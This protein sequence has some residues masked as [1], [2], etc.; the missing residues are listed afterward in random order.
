M[1]TTRLLAGSLIALSIAVQSR[2]AAAPIWKEYANPRFAFRVCYPSWL[3][4]GREPD[5][6][7]GRIFTD[8]SNGEMR[9]WGS[10][11]TLVLINGQEQESDEAPAA[12][13]VRQAADFD[14][15]SFSRVTYRAVHRNWF[16][17]SG[18]KKR[19]IVYVKTIKSDDRWITLQVS[20]PI[21][22]AQKWS[23]VVKR[24][25]SCLRA[26]PP[27]TFDEHLGHK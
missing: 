4:P 15:R 11:L 27:A 12:T 24:A 10:Y 8:G 18:T 25:A 14:A 2:S 7:D 3:R 20:Y 26:L 22:A 16:A 17:L 6:G 5:N 19:E 23:P 1:T 21:A 9:V 13:V